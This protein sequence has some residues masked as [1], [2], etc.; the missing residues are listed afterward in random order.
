MAAAPDWGPD[1]LHEASTW[2]RDAMRGAPGP[3][4]A[5]WLVVLGAIGVATVI[6]VVLRGRSRGDEDPVLNALDAAPVDDEPFTAE[7]RAAVRGAEQRHARGESIPFDQ[8]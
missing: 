3:A 4:K 7:E 5:G 6:A 8:L 2:A 1:P